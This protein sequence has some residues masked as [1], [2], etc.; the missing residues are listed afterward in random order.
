[1]K[2]QPHQPE[3]IPPAILGYEADFKAFVRVWR[4]ELAN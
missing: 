2:E 3:G 1:M 4:P